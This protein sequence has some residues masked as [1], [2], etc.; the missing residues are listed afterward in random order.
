MGP[1]MVE[2]T[3]TL[4]YRELAMIAV[5]R[6]AGGAGLAL[7]LG[8]RLARP[9]RRIIGWTLL[10]LSAVAKI[11]LVAKVFCRREEAA[12]RATAGA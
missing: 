11:P 2:R 12:E 7:L 1:D 8:H 5:T 10:T 4:T 9:Q 3:L 6:A